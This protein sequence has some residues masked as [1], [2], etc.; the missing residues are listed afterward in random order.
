MAKTDG[1]KEPDDDNLTW[2]PIERHKDK[3]RPRVEILIK[4]SGH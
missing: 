4:P 1:K 3:A 2:L